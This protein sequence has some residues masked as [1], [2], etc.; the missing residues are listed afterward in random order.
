[1]AS[2]TTSRILVCAEDPST[3]ADVRAILEGA[4]HSVCGHR[5]GSGGPDETRSFDLA[6]L[7][8]SGRPDT[9]RQFC[10][11]LRLQLL[12]EFVPLLFVTDDHDPAARLASFESGADTCLLRPFA[13]GELLAQVQALL[14]IK[15]LHRRL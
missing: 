6:V 8:G 11:R 15:E 14:R 12:D 4:G 1:M 7:E 13:P 9:A 10:R 3:T 2:T 5:F